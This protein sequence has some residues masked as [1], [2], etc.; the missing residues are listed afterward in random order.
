MLKIL[1]L[2]N[3]IIQYIS[4]FYITVLIENIK[5]IYIQDYQRIDHF[6]LFSNKDLGKKR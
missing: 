6:L 1:K 2:F 4:S 5:M 3:I